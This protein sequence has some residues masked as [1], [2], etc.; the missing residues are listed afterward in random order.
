MQFTRRPVAVVLTL[1]VTAVARASASDANA[2]RGYPEPV[3]EDVSFEAVLNSQPFPRMKIPVPIIGAKVHPEEVH[4]TPSGE[5]VFPRHER[6]RGPCVAIL[7]GSRPGGEQ[8]RSEVAVDLPPAEGVT[9][10]LIDGY[11]P[12]VEN[13]WTVGELKMRQ[14]TFATVG[15]K[16]ESSTGTEPL[17]AMVRY[18][19]TNQ[20]ASEREA[21]AVILFGEAQ[22]G[23]SVKVTPPV[24]P[25]EL[26]FEAPFVRQADGSTA[27]C[28][29]TGEAKVSFKP[30][31]KGPDRSHSLVLNEREESVKAA[32]YTV[33]IERRGDTIAVGQW[34]SPAGVDLYLESSRGHSVP[35]AADVEVIRQGET[36]VPIGKLYRTAFSTDL[37]PAADYIGPGQRSAV[38]PW[39]QLAK[40]LPDGRSKLV[41]RCYYPTDSGRAVVGSWEPIIHFARPGVTPRFKNT[42]LNYTDENR[43]R[44]EMALTPGESKTIDLAIAYDALPPPAG[45]GLATLRFDDELAG[46][47]A[48]WEKELNRNAEFKIP[49]GRIRDAC[50]AC[51]ANNLLLTDR[52]PKTGVLMPHPDA[53]AYEAVWSGDGGVSIQAMDR[54]GYHKEAESMLDYFLAMQGSAKPEGDVQS[55]EGFFCG[56]VGLRWMN[57][58][59]FVL[60][61]MAEHYKLTRDEPW[62]RRVAPQLVKG[63][64]W[65]VRERAR[66]RV[67]EDGR[68]PK[69]YGLLPKG[70][71]SDL[72]LWDHWYWTDTYSYMGLRGTADI[73]K[74]VGMDEEAARLAAEAD[75]CKAC[76]VDSV[77]RS[78]DPAVQPLFVP[79]SP[80][81]T[82]PPTFDF[83]NETWY[84]I[85]SPIYM[86]EAGLLDARGEKS[87]GINHWIEKCGL[88]SGMP[89]FMP[90]SIDPYYVY[91]QSL[92][93]LLRGESAKFA[94]TLYSITA[95]AMGPGTYC[96]IEGHHLVNGLNGEA[97]DANRQPHMH[98][99]SRYIDL[100][101][102]A[103]LL[104]E[105]DVLHLLAG[106]PRGWLA[107]GRQIE[108][109]RAPSLFGQVNYTATSRAGA[110]EVVFRIEPTRWQAANVVL[111]VRPP[112]RCGQIKA[113]TVNGR[114]WT[115]FKGEQVDLGRLSATAEVVCRLGTGL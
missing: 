111:H 9:S 76:I 27:A 10:R 36:P 45:D 107:D 16:Y 26:R 48:F 31:P 8:L 58:N 86:V 106:A 7:L 28:L 87:S 43:L 85:C 5:L 109:K 13:D 102:I 98:S 38:L 40:A 32:E 79:P 100:V 39:A 57:Q 35:V 24:W 91:N 81:R 78:I 108:V 15:G 82:G 42:R 92:A 101:R 89:A 37:R 20:S 97:W 60:W 3:P 69:H 19:I 67:M 93:Q 56:D 73:L 1:L 25:E 46:F 112:T 115:R 65:I 41:A 68:K 23:L 59:G 29:L 66:T 105:G 21:V 62:L 72:D 30:L 54:M 95:Y 83:F 2:L 50:R 6:F 51:I 22:S 61:A 110:G 74:A 77:E 71:P 12:G 113:V 34:Q 14:V 47:R 103:L 84:T 96:T 114:E 4:V 104:E 17:I 70:R 75:D 64:D 94:W 90:G 88:Y 55:A 11:M 63:C 52:H 53:T 49:E 44:I 18:T 99:N 33:E 80:Y